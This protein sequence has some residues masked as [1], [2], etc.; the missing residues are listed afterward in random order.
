L[1]NGDYYSFAIRLFHRLV[2]DRIG[3]AGRVST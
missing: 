3:L 1:R 2:A